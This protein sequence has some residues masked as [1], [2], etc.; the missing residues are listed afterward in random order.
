MSEN[1]KTNKK[2]NIILSI[3]TTAFLLGALVMSCATRLYSTS[4]KDYPGVTSTS[5][6]F[7]MKPD[8][9][10]A[11]IFLGLSLVAFVLGLVKMITISR[12][13]KRD[14]G[15]QKAIFAFDIITIIAAG[16][17]CCSLALLGRVHF[18]FVTKDFGNLF[19]F[20]KGKLRSISSIVCTGVGF[21]AS[22]LPCV[23]SFK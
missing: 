10:L 7:W 14:T 23:G 20:A 2:L 18:N 19:D 3:L 22:I 15:L 9:K 16:L 6:S 4:M 21:A 13:Q 1:K 11:G 17:A 12:F 8:W 5:T